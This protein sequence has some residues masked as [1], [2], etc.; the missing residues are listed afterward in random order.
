M[1]LT[2]VPIEALEIDMANV[3]QAEPGAEG[4]AELAALIQAQGL[5]FPL[6]AQGDASRA[7]VIDGG[8]RLR[9]LR[10]LVALGELEA[11]HPVPCVLADPGDRAGAAAISLAANMGREDLHPVD[12]AAAFK[13]LRDAGATDR[14]LAKR[15]GVSPRTVQRRLRMGRAAPELL[16]RCRKGELGLGV[17]EAALADPDPA[18]QV[19]AVDAVPED[20]WNRAG[21]IRAQLVKGKVPGNSM[22]ASFVTVEAYEAAGGAVTAGMPG[23]GSRSGPYLDDRELLERLAL[24]KLEKTAEAERAKGWDAG[25]GLDQPEAW[26]ERHTQVAADTPED[27]DKDLRERGGVRVHLSPGWNGEIAR[28]V[29]VP[30][31]QDDPGSEDGN[32]AGGDG[33]PGFSA[34]L[35][36][37]LGRMRLSIARAALAEG[38]AGLARDLLLHSLC[39]QLYSRAGAE[40]ECRGSS[41]PALADVMENGRVPASVAGA[42]ALLAAREEDLLAWLERGSPEARWQALRAMGEGDRDRL[43]ACCVARMLL[44]GLAATD[45]AAAELEID[46]HEAFDPGPEVLSRMTKAQL[47][48]IGKESLPEEEFDRVVAQRLPKAELVEGLAKAFERFRKH[49]G[50]SPWI[51]AGIAGDE[52]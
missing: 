14:Q 30:E 44:P 51:P 45:R 20:H 43:L 2:K 36:G 11:G 48:D 29:L 52:D 15:F 34:A 17:L 6:I 21:E 38:P 50:R 9:A 35:R 16:A 28:L 8:R 19:A 5:L 37:D 32:A 4:L 23:G 10:S 27:V 3:R 39:G 31:K 18:K 24:E 22:L 33:K 1:E 40:L 47:A 12:Q 13:V 25:I 41:Q 49:H 42:D 26:W 46:W 7:T